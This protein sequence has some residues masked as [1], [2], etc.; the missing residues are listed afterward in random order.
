MFE[1]FKKIFRV[2]PNSESQLSR[3]AEWLFSLFSPRAKSGVVVSPSTVVGMSAVWRAVGLIS[4]SMGIMTW[5]VV[6]IDDNDTRRIR[7]NH[8]IHYLLNIE[9]SEDY[10]PFDWFYTMTLIS[11]IRGNSFSRI[12]RDQMGMPMRLEILDNLNGEIIAF[13]DDMG[14]L[15]YKQQLNETWGP[16]TVTGRLE[17]PTRAAD[18]IH[19]KWV[20]MNG[21][22]GL[23]P[24]GTHQD[25][26]G[27]GLAARDLGNIFFKNGAH[28]GGV[29]EHPL[30]LTQDAKKRLATSWN[31]TFSGVDNAGRTAILDEG[32]KY[33]PFEFDPVKA[34]M[35]ESQKFNVE[36]IARVFGVPPHLLASLDRA[37]FNNIEHL[38][39]EFK[40]FTVHPWTVRISQELNR[41]LFKTSERGRM[42]VQADLSALMQGDMKSQAEYLRGLVTNGVM[43]IN[44]GRRFL[45]MN[46]VE[47]G[48]VHMWPL[49]MTTLENA[50]NTGP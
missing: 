19:F 20:T 45:G 30:S 24:I 17:K 37:T 8:P 15:W 34:Q 40:Q 26:F 48:D 1:F 25:T 5:N 29:I 7:R 41:K 6:R 50:P 31:A 36:D 32:M 43:S 18:I 16:K 46:P 14:G 9:P 22:G 12:H 11:L 44:D 35:L 33:H 21:L 42:A 4:E 3:P 38:S 2:G 39:L 47:G 27:F 13:R 28:L 23:D 49:N 10:T